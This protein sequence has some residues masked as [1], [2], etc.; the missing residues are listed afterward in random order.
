MKRFLSVLSTAFL[1]L[2]LGATQAVAQSPHFIGTPTCTKSLS[3]GLECTGK[4]AGLGN[5]ATS[6]FLT[7]D[8]VRAT[9][10][11]VNPAGHVAPGQP[12]VFQDVQGPT[13]DITPRNGQIT[14]DV[15]LPPP[16]TPSSSEVCPNGRWTVRLTSLVYQNVVLHIQQGS[17]DILTRGFGTID[18]SGADSGAQNTGGTGNEGSLGNQENTQNPGNPEHPDNLLDSQTG[19]HDDLLPS[20]L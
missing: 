11:C 14:F 1:A 20:F 17:T 4:A 7:A 3:T 15:T 18:P 12:L 13:Q 16:P 5:S 9:Y 10:V 2:G 6:A 8:A 19:R